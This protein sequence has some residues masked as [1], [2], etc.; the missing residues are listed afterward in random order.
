MALRGCVVGDA[1]DVDGDDDDDD[2]D[3]GAVDADSDD[4][5]HVGVVVNDDRVVRHA[6]LNSS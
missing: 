1:G 4:G 2:G 6:C 5:E 3:D